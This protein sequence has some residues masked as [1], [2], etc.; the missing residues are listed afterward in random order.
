M[1]GKKLQASH[2]CGE[3]K[4]C[5]YCRQ[6]K[7]DNHQCPLRKEVITKNWPKLAFI[8]M[9]HFE[10]CS[11]D[12]LNDP[13]MAIIYCEEDSFGNFTQYEF[14]NFKDH[15]IV[16]KTESFLNYNYLPD[17]CQNMVFNSKPLQR[18]TK[19]TQD[20]KTNY[21][22]L[23]NNRPESLMDNL[24]QLITSEKWQNTTFICQDEDS[25]TLVRI[26]STKN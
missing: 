25:L 21:N 20:F 4:S 22:S 13:V 8:G 24:L 5:P 16:S 26:D 1:N 10:N 7:N 9:E 2:M 11:E 19:I 18:K 3:V 6:T 17:F 23:Q 15:T 12:L 14:H